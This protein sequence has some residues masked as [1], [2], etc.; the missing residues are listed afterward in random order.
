MEQDLKKYYKA[1]LEEIR[2]VLGSPDDPDDPELYRIKEINHS[3]T[4]EH[5]KYI[6]KMT[7]NGNVLIKRER[8]RL[9]AKGIIDEKGHY[10]IEDV[11]LPN[12]DN[13][14]GNRE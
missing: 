2:K 6:L 11:I 1:S 12:D 5:D 7:Y 9:M 3:N 8:A 4:E 13:P 10:L 14:E